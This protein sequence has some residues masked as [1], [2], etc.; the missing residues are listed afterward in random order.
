MK[1]K[2]SRPRAL[3]LLLLLAGSAWLVISSDVTILSRYARYLPRRVRT[4]WVSWWPH[5]QF[6]PTPALAMPVASPA[7][8]APTIPLV[9]ATP[10]ATSSPTATSVAVATVTPT[11]SPPP[12]AL[13]TPAALLTSTA[14]PTSMATVT[15]TAS[16]APT[17]TPTPTILPT[18]ARA[19]S[20]SGIKHEWQTW[21]NCGPATL[22]MGLSHFGYKD[23]QADIA[24]VLKPDPEDKHVEPEEMAA[25]VRSRGLEAVVRVNGDL[26]RLKQLLSNGLPVIVEMWH[27]PRPNDGMGHYRLAIGYDD[28][29]G[30]FITYDSL[31]GPGVSIPYGPFDDDWRVFNR[32]YVVVHSSDQAEVVAAI[33]GAD[34]DDTAMYERALEVART[35]AMT[36]PEDAFAWFNVGSSLTALGQYAEAAESFDRARILGLPWRMLWYQFAPFEAYYAAGRFDEVLAL[37]E[38]NLK[39]A[40]NLE[41]SHYYRGLVLEALGQVEAARKAYQLTLKYNPN[42]IRA[43]E[44]LARVNSLP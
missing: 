10:T 32:T 38:A 7:I 42:F 19:I 1:V 35:E 9:Q 29:A 12:T 33:V 18:P 27:T 31:N 4:L 25:Y 24:A 36:N 11:V 26:G 37:A 5:P 30:H 14:T 15:P 43:T 2:F 34:M 28:A 22:A 41:E 8:T 3:I 16:P 40:G 17:A 39:R 20:L 21:N 44:A 13:P 23:T 6:V